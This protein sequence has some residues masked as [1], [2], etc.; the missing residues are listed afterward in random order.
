MLDPALHTELARELQQAEATRVQVE[1]FSRRHPGLTI[2]DSYAIQREWIRLQRDAGRQV[3]GRKIGLTSRA[4]QLAS[5]ITEPDHGVLLDSMLLRD[6]AEVEAARFIVPRFEVEFAF[7]LGKPLA[8]PNATIFDVLRATDYVVPAL[9]LIDAR[10]EQ[11]DRH[12]KAPRTVRDTI[13]DN[14]ANAGIVLGGR[15]MK[16]D[17]VDWR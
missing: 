7:I 14:A 5:Q 3:I 2:D 10:I 17:S 16:P 12:S 9:E 1:Q 8:G 6:G 11:F 13:A 4:M 15:P